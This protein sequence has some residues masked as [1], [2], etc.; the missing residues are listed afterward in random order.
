[1]TYKP[2]YRKPITSVIWNPTDQT[3]YAWSNRFEGEGFSSYNIR[4]I[5]PIS[6]TI[7]KNKAI[8]LNDTTVLGTN[9]SNEGDP[10]CASLCLCDIT[11]TIYMSLYKDIAVYN[12]SW[13]YQVDL[14]SRTGSLLFPQGIG[15]RIKKLIYS[16]ARNAVYSLGEIDSFVFDPIK[17]NYT[18][19]LRHTYG[20]NSTEWT[21]VAVNGPLLSGSIIESVPLYNIQDGV[22]LPKNSAIVA[23][24]YEKVYR[25]M[26]AMESS[27]VNALMNPDSLKAGATA[28][29]DIC[30]LKIA[31]PTGSF[32]D[33]YR[34]E[35][36]NIRVDNASSMVT[37][38]LLIGIREENVNTALGDPIVTWGNSTG[39]H[40]RSVFTRYDENQ[41]KWTRDQ[42][43]NI[44]F[45]MEAGD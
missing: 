12:P 1:L 32:T 38:S 41:T 7:K 40:I 9:S 14:A 21:D 24:S 39:S 8:T 33:K 45:Y 6:L 36:F 28:S 30:T 34:Y 43:G 27:V 42:F 11:N 23:A 4:A 25:L 13:I 17:A 29:G 19:G 16:P 44:Q 3:I 20:D 22:Y 31:K 18:N 37:A 10:W 2:T 5:D 15:T 35:G 26:G